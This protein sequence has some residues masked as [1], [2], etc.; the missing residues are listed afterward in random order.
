M[1]GQESLKKAQERL[2]M[3]VKRDSIIFGEAIDEDSERLQHFWV[4]DGKTTK[5]N[6][7]QGMELTSA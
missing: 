4:Y 6:S 3:K 5:H 7:S 1:A 2:L